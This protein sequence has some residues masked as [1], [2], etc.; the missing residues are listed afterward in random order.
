MPQFEHL[1]VNHSLNFIDPNIHTQNMKDC[2]RDLNFIYEKSEVL[3]WK[4]SYSIL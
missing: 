3:Q 4:I 1:P 2:C